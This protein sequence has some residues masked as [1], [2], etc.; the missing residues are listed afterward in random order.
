[1]VN[2]QGGGGKFKY[3]PKFCI[4]GTGYLISR[5]PNDDLHRS[6]ALE[7]NIAKTVRDRDLVTMEHGALARSRDVIEHHRLNGSSSPVLT[8]TCLS[9]GSL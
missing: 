6:G 7:P 9:Y 2:R 1:M 3:V 5:M 8:A 4:G